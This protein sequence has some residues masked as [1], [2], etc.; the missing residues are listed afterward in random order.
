MKKMKKI[1]ALMLSVMTC[2]VSLSAMTSN[3]ILCPVDESNLEELLSDWTV[4]RADVGETL[5]INKD[6][7]KEAI[8][9]DSGHLLL[10]SNNRA[11][12]AIYFDTPEDVDGSEVK[13][14]LQEVDS[15]YNMSY[16]EHLTN[17]IPVKTFH[18]GNY[19]DPESQEVHELTVDD[20]KKIYDAF[21]EN[22]WID[23]GRINDFKF[24]AAYY[25]YSPGY[26]QYGYI[27]AYDIE[28]KDVLEKYVSEND[29][30]CHL[31]EDTYHEDSIIKIVPDY[32]L[33]TVDHYHLAEQIQNDT[34]IMMNWWILESTST[35]SSGDV[36]LMNNTVGDANEDGELDMSDAV[37]IMQCCS[38]PDSYKLTAQGRYNADFNDDGVTNEDAL[39]IQKTLLE[40]E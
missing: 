24:R 19:T 39:T 21:K 25:T 12:P 13:K 4:V 33:S 9:E 10:V 8:Y 34:G 1:T 16:R 37:Y 27:T 20:A 30:N 15:S 35:L 23:N 7:K 14:V 18:I 6:I 28:N 11:E 32:E 40:I 22:G 17:G 3:A 2:A 38:N 29:L 26:F 5:Y 31:E 36:D